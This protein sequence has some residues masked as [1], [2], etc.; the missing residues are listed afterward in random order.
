MTALRTLSASVAVAMAAADAA[1]THVSKPVITTQK[2]VYK[3]G[4]TISVRGWAEYQDRPAPSVLLDIRLGPPSGDELL[5]KSV[6][7]DA[8]GNFTLDYQWSA[9]AAPGDYVLEVIS[10][11]NDAHRN[12][13]THQKS[14]MRLKVNPG[15]AK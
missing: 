11:C 7:S 15:G 10:Q 14:S 4:E 9:D 1:A 2:V 12:I 5:R 3:A 13:C 8:R 6:R